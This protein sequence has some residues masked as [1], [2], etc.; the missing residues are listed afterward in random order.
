METVMQSHIC[1]FIGLSGNDERLDNLML[2]T[3]KSKHAY[4]PSETGNWGVA[5]ST[6][7]K[8]TDAFWW[9]ERGVF[10]HTLDDYRIG[11]PRFLFDICQHAASASVE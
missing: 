1:L 2:E 5:F 9:E 10:L 7:R 3:K 8:A 4:N 6:S 11:L